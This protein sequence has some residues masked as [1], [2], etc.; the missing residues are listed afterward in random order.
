MGFNGERAQRGLLVVDAET[1]ANPDA[2]AVLGPVKA[3]RSMKDP[4]KIALDLQEKTRKRAEDGALDIDTAQIVAL[5]IYDTRGIPIVLTADE[6]S[7]TDML[8]HWW[9]TLAEYWME[10][11]TG[12][13]VT[14]NGIGLGGGGF[15]LPLLERRS[16]ILKVPHAPLEL[17]KYHSDFRLVDLMVK[18]T[19][20]GLVD[21]K[22]LGVYCR[23]FNISVPEDESTGADVARLVAAGEWDAIAHHC[24]TDLIKTAK[25]AERLGLS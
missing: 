25:L 9:Q 18:L 7:E 23:L 16:Q 2:L 4:L 11:P 13:V 21:Y 15:D 24:E 22:G 8:V 10:L 12:I 14:F 5:G 1:I 20:G 19:W 17:S 3:N 6:M